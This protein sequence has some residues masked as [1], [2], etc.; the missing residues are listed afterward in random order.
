MLVAVIEADGGSY[1]AKLVG[2]KATVDA[3]R[4]KFTKFISELVP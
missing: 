3:H 4:A 1:Y 2:P